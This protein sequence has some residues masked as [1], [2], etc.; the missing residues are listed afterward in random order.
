MTNNAQLNI[1]LDRLHNGSLG[2][3][4]AYDF[5]IAEDNT[6]LFIETDCSNK[7]D[8]TR[9]ERWLKDTQDFVDNTTV[10]YEQTAMFEEIVRFTQLPEKETPPLINCQNNSGNIVNFTHYD[11]SNVAD[12]P[13]M[14]TNKWFEIKEVQDNIIDFWS[15]YS[16]NIAIK[17]DKAGQFYYIR[18]LIPV[19]DADWDLVEVIDQN[20]ISFKKQFG[21][22][23]TRLMS[24][25]RRDGK[26]T[27]KIKLQ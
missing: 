22:P 21:L 24:N 16:D 27:Y 18:M 14:S 7:E 1:F 23:Y 12:T 13:T 5:L 17:Y 6:D 11:Q 26:Y 15:D 8:I 20:L 25:Y 10:N 4:L 2:I 9:F 19:V 3:D